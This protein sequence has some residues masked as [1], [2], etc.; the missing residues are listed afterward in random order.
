MYILY[1]Q[2]LGYRNDIRSSLF[3]KE[4]KREVMEFS[5]SSSKKFSS[6]DNNN[7]LKFMH[8]GIIRDKERKEKKLL[9]FEQ[10]RL[11]FENQIK[12]QHE[13]EKIQPV[14]KEEK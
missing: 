3:T 5:S 10:N 7:I 8:A 6:N 9:N 12:L 4:R 11:E 14:L 2:L 13:F 1:G